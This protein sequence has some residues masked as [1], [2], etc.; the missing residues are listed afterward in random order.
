MKRYAALQP[1]AQRR[2]LRRLDARALCR[3]WRREGGAAYSFCH[4]TC[5][6]ARA[7]AAGVSDRWVWCC[8]CSIKQEGPLGISGECEF[9][10]SGHVSSPV[11]AGA[12]VSSL[13]LTNLQARPLPPSEL[14]P[15]HTNG[16]TGTR[17]EN[18]EPCLRSKQ[19]QEFSGWVE[20]ETVNASVALF[21]PLPS[22]S[23]FFTNFVA[24][25]SWPQSWFLLT[26]LQPR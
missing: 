17:P 19:R 22:F 3:H 20:V 26:R 4:R 8:S 16:P 2:R 9:H 5:E 11:T 18:S 13:A 14:W 15:P 21:T 1:W 10:V 25:V 7:R 23:S 24:T 12:R 6:S